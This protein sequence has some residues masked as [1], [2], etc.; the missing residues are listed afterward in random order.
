MGRTQLEQILQIENVPTE[1]KQIVREFLSE[2]KDSAEELLRKQRENLYGILNSTDDAIYITNPQHEIEFVNNTTEKEFGPVEEKK[3]YQYFNDFTEPCPWCTAEKVINGDTFRKEKTLTRNQKTYEMIDTP[4]RNPDGSVSILAILRDISERKKAE[5]KLKESEERYKALVEQSLQAVTIIQDGKLIYSNSA[6][7]KLLGFTKEEILSFSSEDLV[8]LIHPEDQELVQSQIQDRIK[9]KSIPSE[10]ECR[11]IN[12][13]GEIRWINLFSTLIE[14]NGEPAIQTASIDFTKRKKI[15]ETLLEEKIFIDKALSALEDTFFVFNAENGQPLKWN[16]A[17]SE[18]SGYNDEEILNMTPADFYDGED[19]KNMEKATQEVL[20]KGSSVLTASLVTKVGKRIPYEYIGVFLKDY[21]DKPACVVVIGRDVSEQVIMKEK[22]K[23]SEE[24]FTQFMDHL[25]AAV[26][27][28]DKDSK[29]IFANNFL[30]DVFG[31]EKWIGKTTNELFP[32]EIARKMIATDQKALNEGLQIITEELMNKNSVVNYYQTYKFPIIRKNKGDLLGGISIDITERKQAEEALKESE[33]RYRELFN[34]MSSGVAVYEAINEGEDFVFKDF[35]KAGEKI[36]KT[37]KKQLL[38]TSVLDKFP[39]IKTFGLFEVFQRVWKTGIPEYYPISLYKD[40]RITG[41]RENFIYKLPSGEIVAVYDDVT[42]RKQVEV[43]LEKSEKKYRSLFESAPIGIGI[44]NLEG[45]VLE[46]NQKILE[47]MGYTSEE[48]KTVSLG[49]T[50]VNPE[51]RKKLL[52]EIGESGQVRDFEVQLKRKDGTPYYCLLNINLMELDNQKV[53]L[54]TQ[55]DLTEKKKMDRAIKESEEKYRSFVQ[56]F[57]G[58]AFKGYKDFSIGMFSGSVEE[59]T[60]F[61]ED[62][63]IEKKVVYNQLIHPEDLKQV[64]NEVKDFNA[65]SRRSTQREYRI[66]DKSGNIHFVQESIQKFYDEKKRMEGVYGTIEDITERKIMENALRE[67]EQKYRNIVENTSD[68]IMLTQPNGVVTYLSPACTNVLGYDPDELM[69]SEAWIIHPDDSEKGKKAYSKALKGESGLGLEY[70]V[71]T[72]Q[73]DIKHILHSWSPINKEKKLQLVVSV[74]RDITERKTMEEA[75]QASEEQ[76]RSILNSIGDAM[77]VTDKDTRIILVNPALENWAGNLGFKTSPIDKKV[78]EAYPFL[79][80]KIQDEYQQVLDTGKTLIKEE[81]YKVKEGEYYTETRKIP[82]VKQG[83]VVQIV[84]IVRNITE[85]KK[86]EEQLRYQANL[87]NYVSDAVIASDL[88]FRITSWNKAAEII[89]GWEEEEVIG[90]GVAELLQQEYPYDRREDVVNEFLKD[91]IWQG[92]VIQKHK[93]GTSLNILAS[94]ALIK[95]ESGTPMAAL[96]VNRDITH[97]KKVEQDLQEKERL[98]ATGQLAAGVA[99]QLNTP[100]S[101]INLTT[102]VITHLIT[103]DNSDLN[104]ILTEL[105]GLKK[106]TKTC[107]Q[108][109]RHLLVFSRRITITQDSINLKLLL[110]EIRFNPSISKRLIENN[111]SFILDMDGNINVTGDKGLLIQVFENIII[112]SIDAVNHAQND[113]FI[114]ISL[115]ESNKNIKIVIEDNGEGIRK[116]DLPRVFEPFFST[117]EVGQGTGLGLSIARGIIE[118][119]NGQIK[120]S[121]TY[122]KGTEVVIIFPQTEN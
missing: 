51:D 102:E 35:N 33:E 98:A 31:G 75:L 105:E 3:C 103:N 113:S 82:I 100:L 70:R 32:E 104:Q 24:L 95:D 23:E 117:K 77:H 6:A 122:G 26:F 11:L 28:K 22:L 83:K 30:K 5:L 4:F 120:I 64:N 42:T 107:A 49:D 59:I 36:E 67:S 13:S 108:I 90:K 86:A 7:E 68:V 18:V 52:K 12:K 116:K 40:Q 87:L 114:K 58:I 39:G 27:I 14:I 2:N 57:Q 63:F 73:G 43:A 47:I 72:K 93:N 85:R 118:K 16:K 15:E 111:I 50:Y 37:P 46:T 99:H 54:T 21:R 109:V 106:Q 76:Y 19:L 1:A 41:W 45:Y 110:E 29:T 69:G 78:L 97:R 119:N 115:N 8:H 79:S 44:A 20:E 38:G 91:G 56:N 84:T 80:N 88:D 81:H 121:S 62:D 25:P 101:N 17:F 92:E 112:N 61:T 65:S 48:I 96:A 66:I 53:L 94:V 74:I 34:N 89:Y 71:I 9:G 10:Y 55:R 60:G